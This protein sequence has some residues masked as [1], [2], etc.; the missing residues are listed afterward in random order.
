M[1]RSFTFLHKL[2]SGLDIR[3]AV[4]VALGIC[5]ILLGVYFFRHERHELHGIMQGIG[6]ARPAWI[7]AGLMLAVVYVLLQAAMYVHGFRAAKGQIT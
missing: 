5:S 3:R 4:Q 7:V 1:R 6:Q 2:G